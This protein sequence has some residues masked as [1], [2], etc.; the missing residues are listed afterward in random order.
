MKIKSP[1][2]SDSKLSEEK[3]RLGFFFRK[4]ELEVQR[5]EKDTNSNYMLFQ[6][7]QSTEQRKSWIK[8]QRRSN[9]EQEQ[10]QERMKWEAQ[11]AE[12]AAAEREGEGKAWEEQDW[13]KQKTE[14][15]KSFENST[16]RLRITLNR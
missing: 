3:I 14:G 6:R 16:R 13:S 1:L 12:G 5:E 4:S 8:V 9:S 7:L 11:A 10:E 2:D 15:K